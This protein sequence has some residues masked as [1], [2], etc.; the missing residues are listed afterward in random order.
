MNPCV[1]GAVCWGHCCGAAFAD[2]AWEAMGGGPSDL[3]FPDSFV[4]TWDVRST[5][6]KV[7]HRMVQ[8]HQAQLGT[9][10]D[11]THLL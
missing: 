6:V 3:T 5:L 7:G 8:V 10:S 2:R 11:Q 4:G 1:I 9:H